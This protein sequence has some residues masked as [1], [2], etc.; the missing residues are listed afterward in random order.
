MTE[1]TTL[2]AIL[3][4]VGITLESSTINDPTYSFPP[5]P[6]GSVGRKEG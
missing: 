4:S 1:T 3:V 6:G 2:T 5:A